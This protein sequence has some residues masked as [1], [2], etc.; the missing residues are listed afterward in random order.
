MRQIYLAIL[1]GG[2][3]VFV[4]LLGAGEI[5]SH[6]SGQAGQEAADTVSDT[7][8]AV[9]DNESSPDDVEI[10]DTRDTS[11]SGNLSV[12]DDGNGV[13]VLSQGGEEHRIQPV[14]GDIPVERLVAILQDLE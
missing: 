1:V 4:V 6:T 13:Y 2:I 9:A 5:V 11:V 14:E 7:V 3:L 8:S 10:N 12:T